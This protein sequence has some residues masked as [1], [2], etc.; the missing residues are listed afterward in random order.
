MDMNKWEELA[1][2]F[3]ETTDKLGM[4]I[5]S[6][7][8]DLVVTLNGL[9]FPT[10]ASCWG[11]IERVIAAPWVDFQPKLTPEMQAKK[12]EAQNLWREIKKKESED[13]PK[14]ELIKMLDKFH[15]LEKEANEP[16]LLLTEKILE[17]LNK[18]YNNHSVD[19]EVILVLR[20]IGNSTVRLESNGAIVQEIK[21][22]E[23]RENNLLKYQGEMEKFSAFAKNRFLGSN[24]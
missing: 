8:F 17:V 11:H 22:Q 12:E 9:E 5:D 2:Q 20:K 7:V 10:S 14:A 16:L 24:K 19:A 21:S 18:F 15:Q 23:V 3:K 1:K 6:G 13:E 4:K